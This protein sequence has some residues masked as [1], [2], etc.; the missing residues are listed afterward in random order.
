MF[1][2]ETKTGVLSRH[3]AG[4]VSQ[5]A[6]APDEVLTLQ[7]PGSENVAEIRMVGQI[8]GEPGRYVYVNPHSTPPSF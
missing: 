2:E 1:S 4:I 7:L 8:G 5:F 3:G 6:F